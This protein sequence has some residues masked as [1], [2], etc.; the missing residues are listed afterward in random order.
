MKGLLSNLLFIVFVAVATIS[1]T[2]NVK[3]GNRITP[4]PFYDVRIEDK[5]WTERIGTVNKVTVPE[6]DPKGLVSF[7]YRVS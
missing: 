5:F 2:A 6:A 7:L 3:G 1:S 4:V